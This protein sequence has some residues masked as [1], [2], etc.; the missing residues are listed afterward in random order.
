MSDRRHGPGRA[1]LVAAL[2]LAAAALAPAAAAATPPRVDAA[3]TGANSE[4]RRT[5]PITHTP[6]AAPRVALSMGPGKLSGL[7]RGDRLELSSEVQVTVD[8]DRPSPRCAGR[9]YDYDPQ[10]TVTLELARRKSANAPSRVVARRRL[11]C[12]QRLP[13]RQHHCPVVFDRTTRVGDDFPCPL[14]RCYANVVVAASSPHARGDQRMIIG[15]NKPNGRIVQDKGRLNAIRIARGVSARRLRTSDLRRRSLRLRPRR[16]VVLSQ[17]VE[18]LERGDVLAVAAA[19]RSDVRRLGYNALVG[20]QLIVARGP[21]ATAPSR[22]VRRSVWLQGLVS[23]I[24]GT[25]CTPAQSPCTTRKVAA[26]KLRRD[27]LGGSGAPAPLFVNLVIRT[28][29][30]RVGREHGARL[31]LLRGKLEVRRYAGRRG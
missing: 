6:G 1:A 13:N 18:G 21:N 23:P 22:L 20:G 29:Q 7:R 9:P 8:C 2:A 15:A 30:K 17:K 25:N 19:L 26:V 3:T 14:D 27:A 24:N 16:K 10:V 11:R 5:V 12:R 31:R 28:K 4:L